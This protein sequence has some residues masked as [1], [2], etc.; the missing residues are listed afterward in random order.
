MARKKSQ[1][2][3]PAPAEPAPA[4]KLHP[5]L[6]ARV[7]YW[8]DMVETAIRDKP[9]L[10]AALVLGTVALESSGRA[11]AHNPAGGG[12][13]AWGLMQV[14]TPALTDYNR[15]HGSAFQLE[16]LKDAGLGLEVGTWYLHERLK[17][18]GDTYT[19]LRAYKE[20]PTGARRDQEAGAGYA[21]TVLGYMAAFRL[22]LAGGER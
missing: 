20:G 3:P 16:Q 21:R 7:V 17:E 8:R 12:K 9:K 22:H 5:A 15:A 19:A 11:D 6:L 13:G 1:S 2:A 4:V 18:F 10:S 14:R